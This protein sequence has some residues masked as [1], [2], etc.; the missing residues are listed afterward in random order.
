MENDVSNYS[1]HS[2]MKSGNSFNKSTNS[3]IVSI[4]NFESINNQKIKINS[5][6]S[7]AAMKQLGY[8]TEDL[9]YLTFKE[10][11]KANPSMTGASKE[12]KKNKYEYLENLRQEK[13]KEIKERRES[14][15]PNQLSKN[16]RSK[17]RSRPS[18]SIADQEYRSTAI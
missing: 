17:N 14:I 6:R 11:L 7:V 2:Q 15:D 5:P 4:D 1:S 12:M 18:T 16:N 9:R 10:F 3:R 13:I 8:T